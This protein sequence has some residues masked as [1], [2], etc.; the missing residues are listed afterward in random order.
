MVIAGIGCS[1]AARATDVVAAVEEALRHY[2]L[3]RSV[4]EA[5]ATGSIKAGAPA[6]AEAAAQLGLPLRRISGAD[7]AL[8]DNEALSVSER[9][10]VLTGVGSLSEAAAL[11]AAGP[12]AT[13]YGPRL[14]VGPVTCALA[15]KGSQ[16]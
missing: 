9:S 4:L 6:V 16:R 15:R 3:A 7:L 1:S 12:G 14:A 13:L 5:L 8:A 11:A 2:G 10:L